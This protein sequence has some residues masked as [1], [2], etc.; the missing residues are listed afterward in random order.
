[1]HSLPRY[2]P[3]HLQRGASTD[4][5]RCHPGDSEPRSQDLGSVRPAYPLCA[6]RGAGDTGWGVGAGRAA[7]CARMGAS[8]SIC[9]HRRPEEGDRERAPSQREPVTLAICEGGGLGIFSFTAVR[10]KFHKCLLHSSMFLVP[11]RRPT[12]PHSAVL[13][14]TPPRAAFEWA[15]QGRGRNAQL[16]PHPG[17]A[18]GKAREG[19]PAWS[20][21]GGVT[22]PPGAWARPGS[23]GTLQVFASFS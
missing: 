10:K 8:R 4:C 15:V 17:G 11:G 14:G 21:V 1:M 6:P 18:S 22:V 19:S 3:P 5:R 12:P 7:F 23:T 13:A 20:P 16:G 9:H 2:P